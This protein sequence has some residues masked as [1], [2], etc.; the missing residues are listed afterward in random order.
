VVSPPP[1]AP[2]G[3]IN[4]IGFDGYLS[5]NALDI[6]KRV[7]EMVINT[8]FKIDFKNIYFLPNKI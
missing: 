6:I 2:Y 1:P 7:I 5:A 3:T 4:L 8:P